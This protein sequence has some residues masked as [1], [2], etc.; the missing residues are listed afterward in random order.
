MASVY[1]V[2]GPTA[3]GKSDLALRIA[4]LQHAEL[5]VCDA[6][7]VY[8]GFDLGS[9]KPTPHEQAQAVHHGLDLCSPTDEMNAGRFADA[10]HPVVEARL[11]AG[12]SLV[13]VVG[14]F[15]YYRA[16]AYGLGPLPRGS[17]ELRLRYEAQERAD[18]G[19][20]SREVARIDPESHRE[21]NGRNLPRLVRALEVFEL[22]GKTASEW[23]REHGGFTQSR[24]PLNRVMLAPDPVV[25]AKRLEQ[26]TQLMLDAGWIEEVEQLR[27]QGIPRTAKPMGAIGYKEI[28]AV[29][30]G[31]L[32]RAQL[33][34][35]I[36]I[37]TRQYAKRQR[38]FF[39]H[40]PDV[41]VLEGLGSD[42]GLDWLEQQNA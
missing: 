37:A 30:D 29:L 2:L 39:A 24:W 31:E 3:S 41:R 23:R 8:R 28:N 20:L 10:V 27:A 42:V 22:T 14:T 33:Q 25:A 40:E 7:M 1:V 34:E 32:E 11:A 35:R 15:L 19:F 21:A 36:V 18:P 17:N 4:K 16:L 9:N 6:V 13:F 12:K 5:V 38:N 26:R